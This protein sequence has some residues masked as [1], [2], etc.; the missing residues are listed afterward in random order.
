MG[1]PRIN[2][3]VRGWKYIKLVNG[4]MLLYMIDRIRLFFKKPEKAFIVLAFISGMG[5]LITIPPL[6]TPDEIAHFY[7]SYQIATGQWLLNKNEKG[8]SVAWVPESIPKTV[9]IL[10]Y[11]NPVAGDSNKEYDLQNTRH[12]LSVRLEKNKQ[13]LLDAGSA[14]GHTPLVYAPQGI[15]LSILSLF[16][17]RP[18]IMI[19]AVRIAVLLTWIFLAYFAI[20]LLPK[21]KWALVGILLIP[22][23]SAQSISPGVDTIAIGFGILFVSLIFNLRK[24]KIEKPS[25]KKKSLLVLSA[26]MMVL[27]KPV[28]ACILPMIYY[29]GRN[30]IK[31]EKI[32][33]IITLLSPIIIYLLWS[34]VFSSNV[35]S[36]PDGVVPGQQLKSLVSQPWNFFV[37]FFNTFFFQWGDGVISSLI[38]NFGPLDTPLSQPF[39]ILGF[40]LVAFYTFVSYEREG[41]I[42]NRWIILTLLVIYL[43]VVCLAM[44]LV[45]SPVGFGIFYG[46]QGR[47]F[48]IIPIVLI[49]SGCLSFLHASQKIYKNIALLGST[50]LLLISIITIIFRYYIDYNI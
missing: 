7:R 49:M 41:A 11:D 20:K 36:L 37:I 28:M 47:Y 40:L 46:L 23:M 45:Y 14:A 10:A 12:A 1:N 50:A 21:R 16:N 33:T 48:L 25:N 15:T 17:A 9:R 35:W 32:F 27:A 26:I 5:F 2:R 13:K 4:I 34:K 42:S 39:V 43:F 6:Q 24:E 8:H 22:M 3:T 30:K 29:M 38:G 31:K 18:L 19:Y 44:Y